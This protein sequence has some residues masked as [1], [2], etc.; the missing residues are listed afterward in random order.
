M[1]PCLRLLALA[2]VPAVLIVTGFRGYIVGDRAWLNVMLDRWNTVHEG[3]LALFSGT[4]SERDIWA[5]ALLAA[6][7]I[8]LLMWYAVSRQS[9]RLAAFISVFWLLLSLFGEGFYPLALVLLSR[10]FLLWNAERR[11]H[12]MS[13]EERVR[14]SQK[15]I[16]KLIS[17]WGI[18]AAFGW[19]TSAMRTRCR[20]L[21]PESTS[22]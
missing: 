14:Q 5:F 22:V 7:L 12:R 4:A 17:L 18:D 13:I 20:R 15:L 16:F 2:P 1:L 21:S 19:E 11:R 8:G 6:V 3:G 10:A 9:S